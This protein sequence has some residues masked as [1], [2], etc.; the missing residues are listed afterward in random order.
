MRAGRPGNAMGTGRPREEKKRRGEATALKTRGVKR[1][2]G[3]RN[4]SARNAPNGEK[5]EWGSGRRIA[6]AEDALAGEN[7]TKMNIHRTK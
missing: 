3:F 1:D 4:R 6:H 5:E 7:S 2:S